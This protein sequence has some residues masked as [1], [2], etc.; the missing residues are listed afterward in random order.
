MLIAAFAAAAA[1]TLSPPPRGRK[2][3][4][5]H[6]VSR[7]AQARASADLYSARAKRRFASFIRMRLLELRLRGLRLAADVVEKRMT[8]DDLLRSP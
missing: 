1:L 2:P 7:P 3:T 5:S 4:P 6:A 8:L